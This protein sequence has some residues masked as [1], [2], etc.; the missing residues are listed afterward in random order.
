MEG[1]VLIGEIANQFLTVKCLNAF[2][3]RKHFN[4]FKTKFDRNRRVIMQNIRDIDAF[5][6]SIKVERYTQTN[7]LQETNSA[8]VLP[9]SYILKTGTP[10][11]N[12]EIYSEL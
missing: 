1:S 8:F 12:G 2:K 5:K 9:S 6:R 10:P 7:T 3:Q 4:S 11:M